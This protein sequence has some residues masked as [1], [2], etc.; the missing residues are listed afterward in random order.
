MVELKEDLITSHILFQE[1]HASNEYINKIRQTAISDFE[2]QGFP[3]TKDEEWKYTNLS[4]ILKSR[5]KLFPKDNNSLEYKEI[6]SYLI[7]EIE[8]YKLVFVDGKFSNHLSE[9]THDEADICILSSSFSNSIYQSLVE[10]YFN[11]TAPN[12]SGWVSLN[13]AYTNEGAFIHVC[14]NTIVSRP[15]QIIY[16]STK[17]HNT[18]YNPRNLVLVEDNSSVQII[19]SHYNLTNFEA[20]TNVVTEIFVEKNSTLDYYKLQN[21]ALTSSIVD[22]T[23]ISQKEKSICNVFTFSFGSN[24]TRN[25]L[26]FYQQG[27]HI[28]SNLN[29]ITLIDEDQLVD[30]HTLVD[31]KYPNCYSN[32]RYKGLFSGNSK[33]VF[34][35]KIYVHPEAQKTNALQTN[36]NIIL[37]KNA[38]VDTKPQLE[39]F[40]DDVKC[41]HGCTVGELNDDALFYLQTRGIPKN[42][43]KALLTYAFSSDIL[44]SINIKALKDRVSQIIAKKLNV[45]TDFGL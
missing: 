40:A 7:D 9:T 31:H 39:I 36:N 34:N 27:E 25:N 14:K 29:G 19:E 38:S 30:H 1:K 37:S 3:N 13:T 45:D 16:F 35:G 18:F 22:N 21:D 43:A 33:G 2:K 8:S 20:L 23:H 4:S 10:N 26:H 17:E 12:N 6:K 42:E 5:Y 32:E 41:S 28:E 15:I 24:I 11:K 44:N